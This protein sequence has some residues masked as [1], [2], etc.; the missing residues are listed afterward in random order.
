[1]H[2]E[3]R[4]KS[5]WAY[6]YLMDAAYILEKKSGREFSISASIQVNANQTFNDN[7]YEH[8]ELGAPFLGESGRQLI[9]FE[10]QSN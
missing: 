8:E 4:N 3:V 9:G 5:G 1:M 2:L 7:E 6:D 10:E